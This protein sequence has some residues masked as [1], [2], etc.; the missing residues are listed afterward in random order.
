MKTMADF[1]QEVM[2]SVPGCP[3]PVAINAIRNSV[4]EFLKVT[5][6][7]EQTVNIPLLADVATATIVLADERVPSTYVRGTI[8]TQLVQPVSPYQLDDRNRSWRVLRGSPA[9]GAYIENGLLRVVPIPVVDATISATFS[10]VLSRASNL[11]DDLIVE[12]WL[13][14]IADGALYRLQ[15][16]PGVQWANPEQAAYHKARFE[17]A[18]SDANVNRLTG[19]TNATLTASPVRFG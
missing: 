5:S 2:P 17:S 15:A 18:M 8:G 1:L 11:V 3:Q 9:S 14:E 16:L 6:I 13:E 4:I 10:V 7:L 12:D 19:G